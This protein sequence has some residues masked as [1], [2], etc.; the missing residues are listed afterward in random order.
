FLGRR[1]GA[2]GVSRPVAIKVIHPH[3]AEEEL[4]VRMF[5]DEARISSHISHSN[6]VY[7]ETFG[8]HQGVYYMAME[9]VDGCSLEQVLKTLSIR[10]HL[11]APE[12]AVYIAIEAASGLHAAHETTGEDGAPLGIV[13]R[14]VSPSNIL[15]T[16]DGRVK[17]IDFGIAKARG[18]LSA[19]STG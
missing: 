19:T 8:E 14:D 1:H 10:G 18:R 6:V 12:I 3:L 5:I 2:A 4:V 17:V 15:L 9:Y 16:R 7:I 11:L 13:H